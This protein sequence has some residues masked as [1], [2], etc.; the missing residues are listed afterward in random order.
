MA[1]VLRINRMQMTTA[2]FIKSFR[3][4]RREMSAGQFILEDLRLFVRR[5]LRIQRKVETTN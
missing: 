3:N 1:R 2:A 5:R 4:N